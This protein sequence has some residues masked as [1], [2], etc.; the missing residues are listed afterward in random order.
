MRSTFAQL[1]AKKWYF[2]IV[3]PIVFALSCIIILSVP[4]YYTC[5]IKLAPEYDLGGAGSVGDLASSFGIDLGNT[6]SKDAYTPTLYPDLIKSPD[7]I[8]KLFSTNVKTQDGKV[9]T[10]YFD[11]LANR[12]K[13]AFWQGL[14]SKKKEQKINLNK[15][16]SFELTKD[17]AKIAEKVKV[18]I[19]CVVDRKTDVISVSVTD[20]DPYI[21]ATLCDSIRVKLQNFITQYRT[22]K[23]R[24]DVI[25][26]QKLTNEAKKEYEHARQV[27]AAYSDANQD[28]V[29][30]AY[31]SKQE[32]LENDMQL[33]FNTYQSTSN[34]LQAAKA[35]VQQSTPAF[36]ILQ[37]ASVPTKPAGPKRMIFVLVMLALAAIITSVVILRKGIIDIFA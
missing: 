30:Q 4:R 14:F 2:V 32:D 37:G 5:E 19:N 7:F 22:K 16:N 26:Y 6:P 13:E 3:L 24:K 34:Q 20:Q 27:Y 9:S 21:A 33:K 17:Q 11:Y 25:Y 31:Q 12:Q 28:A 1:K 10:N 15:I 23:A 29:L 8:V 18:N 36:T 35:K